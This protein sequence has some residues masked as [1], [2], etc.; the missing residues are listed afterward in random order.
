MNK[1]KLITSLSSAIAVSL[2]A[3]QVAQATEN[4]FALQ[5]VTTATQMAEV[6]ADKSAEGKSSDGKCGNKM[7]EGACNA[8]AGKAK[9]GKCGEGKCGANKMKMKEGGCSGSMAPA[10]PAKAK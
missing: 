7:K 1:T 4:P 2:L 6:T 10:A 3:S 9:E 8:A 5:K